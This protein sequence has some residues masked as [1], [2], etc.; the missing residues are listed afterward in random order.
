MKKK[1][2]VT[3]CL[4]II[5]A[6]LLNVV[7]FFG[8]PGK[9]SE[10]FGGMLDSETGIRQ[11]IDLAG[12]SVITFE[13]QAENPTDDQMQAV[14]A[15]YETR[16]TG[17]GYTE[18]RVSV[19]EGGKVNIEIPSGS[20]PVSEGEKAE[21]TTAADTDEAV[22]LLSQIAK[23]T[24]RD[25]DN[26]IVL[27]G[28]DVKSA[29]SVYGQPN[30]NA[31]QQ[32]YVTVEFTSEGTKKFAEATGKAASESQGRNIIQIFMDENVVSAP[33][34]SE[35]ITSSSCIISGQFTAEDSA[36]LAS[37]INSGNLPFEMKKIT[38]ETVGAELG[39]DAL[40]RSLMAAGIGIILVMLF[41]IWRYRLQGL[42]A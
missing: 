22:E 11:G 29:A 13:A 38:Q 10:N 14:K 40:P 4:L 15:V 32:Y 23:L 35:Q 17:A 8:L 37:Q 12:G 39:Q 41:M 19:N 31:V 25:A 1:S 3:F 26:N 27:N 33:M 28:E 42:M 6:I 24:F 5:V 21:G 18:S 30:E 34:V 20:T 16:L 9:F 7:A 2:I 36:R